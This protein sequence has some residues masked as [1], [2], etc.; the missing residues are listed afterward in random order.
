MPHFYPERAGWKRKAGSPQYQVPERIASTYDITG[1]I[2]S[3]CQQ[4]DG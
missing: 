2:V 1:M 3:K 4:A